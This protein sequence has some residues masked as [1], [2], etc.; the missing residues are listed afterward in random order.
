M[1]PERQAPEWKQLSEIIHNN[2]LSSCFYGCR[3]ARLLLTPKGSG[4]S[5]KI[6]KFYL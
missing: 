6:K 3:F 1:S 2:N 4:K 5:L